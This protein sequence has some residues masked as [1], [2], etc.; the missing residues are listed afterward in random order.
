MV[1]PHVAYRRNVYTV[2]RASR[3]SSF[4]SSGVDGQIFLENCYTGVSLSPTSRMGVWLTA[5]VTSVPF[6]SPQD[7]TVHA[8]V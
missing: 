5:G 4:V 3:L 7:H 1:P 2:S 8:H 6:F